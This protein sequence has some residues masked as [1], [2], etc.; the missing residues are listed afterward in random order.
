[1]GTI[2]LLEPGKPARPVEHNGPIELED[3]YRLL[4][5]QTV[6]RKRLG[7]AM[8]GI[9]IDLWCDDEGLLNDNVRANRLL[10]EWVIA[11]TFLLCTSVEGDTFPFTDLVMASAV[12][13]KASTWPILPEDFPKPGPEIGFIPWPEDE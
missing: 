12:L 8:P 7:E 10:G 3:L 9:S 2:I 13:A 6:D 4:D 5:C 11:G 1:M